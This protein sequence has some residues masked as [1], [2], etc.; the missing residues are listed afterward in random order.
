MSS[1]H[2][3]N[4]SHV[5]FTPNSGSGGFQP[6]KII[7]QLQEAGVDVE[8][9]VGKGQDVVKALG[10]KKTMTGVGVGLILL[11]MIVNED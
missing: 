1:A 9:V 7:G 4:V 2:D 5:D 11:S 6:Q 3:E 8:S 10:V